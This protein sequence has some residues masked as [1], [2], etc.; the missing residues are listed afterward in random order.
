MIISDVILVFSVECRHPLSGEWSGQVQRAAALVVGSLL[1]CF[2]SPSH[3]ADEHYCRWFL[4]TCFKNSW[5]L[6]V[7]SLIRLIRSQGRLKKFRGLMEYSLLQRKDPKNCI[8]INLHCISGKYL[9]YLRGPFAWSK[10]L[11]TNGM[12]NYFSS[13]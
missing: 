3:S 7:N 11:S 2:D 6:L 4:R 10:E 8:K 1:T 5:T 13:F 9:T 12:L